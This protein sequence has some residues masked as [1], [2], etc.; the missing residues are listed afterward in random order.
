MSKPWC[1]KNKC[2][3]PLDFKNKEEMITARNANGTGPSS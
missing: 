2:M 1:E 3:K